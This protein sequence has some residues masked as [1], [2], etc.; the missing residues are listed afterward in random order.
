MSEIINSIIIG[1][2]T[3]LSTVEA[4]KEFYNVKGLVE[5]EK[6]KTFLSKIITGTKDGIERL[7]N[8][9]FRSFDSLRIFLVFAKVYRILEKEG[10]DNPQKIAEK[11][12]IPS[13][14][15]ISENEDIETDNNL[16]ERWA[17]LLSHEAK[18]GRIHSKFLSFMNTLEQPEAMILNYLYGKQFYTERI[19]NIYSE[20]DLDK[21]LIN[22]SIHMI[23]GEN[24]CR[25]EDSSL[26]N[27]IDKFGK[28]HKTI[29][30]TRIGENFMS[31]VAPEKNYNFNLK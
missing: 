27:S 16:R 20:I 4:T 13:L 10:V 31:V 15:M 30:L 9:N 18:G 24:L 11:I 6:F 14:E 23:L 22:D 25:Y 7:K 3:G 2:T 8:R 12:L 17:F 1:V 21:Q 29:V 19:D 26:G 5:N 28:I